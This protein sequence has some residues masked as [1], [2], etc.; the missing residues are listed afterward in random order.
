METLKITEIEYCPYALR[1]GVL[2]EQLNN[3]KTINV[4]QRT[5]TSLIDR[6]N[7]DTGQALQVTQLCQRWFEQVK[8]VWQLEQPIYLELLLAAATLHEIGFDINSSGYHK[9]GH[10]ILA[11]AD[12][13]GFT[14]EQQSALAWLVGNQRKKITPLSSE[15]CYLLNRQQLHHLCALL[16]LA[17]LLC[18]QRQN[19]NEPCETI[20][21]DTNN[22]TLHLQANWLLERPIVDSELS[23]E[24]QH[25][26]SI[27]I[28]LLFSH[29]N[30][31]K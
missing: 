26:K 17:I 29:H 10:Y 13:A 19:E 14:Q 7:V 11:H 5:V 25:L 16:R 4:R 21:V 23:Y 1:E 30:A 31:A 15:H 20:S 18:Q 28:S 3:F 24:Q 27:D 6:F 2:Y 22:L 12:L 8:Y 9:H